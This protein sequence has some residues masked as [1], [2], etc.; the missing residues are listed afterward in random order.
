[1]WCG[2]APSSLYLDT[3]GSSRRGLG[4]LI[5]DSRASVCFRSQAVCRRELTNEQERAAEREG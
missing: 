5:P 4:L 2:G 3:T 1:M